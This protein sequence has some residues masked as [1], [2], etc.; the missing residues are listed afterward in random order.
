MLILRQSFIN[1]NYQMIRRE[2]IKII[3][4]ASDNKDYVIIIYIQP[5]N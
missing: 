4:I 3:S 2:E 5:I 1:L